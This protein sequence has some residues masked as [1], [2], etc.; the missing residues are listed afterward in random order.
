MQ[1][2]WKLCM[3]ALREKSNSPSAKNRALGEANRTSA[4]ENPTA[5]PANC[6]RMETDTPLSPSWHR[7]HSAM[8]RRV[9][10]I[11]MHL[12]H[13]DTNNHYGKAGFAVRHERT[14]KAR[15][16]TVKILSCVFYRDAWQRAHDTLLHGKVALPCAF[17]N[18][19]W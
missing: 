2:A 19:T 5:R 9:F 17:S 16:Y 6:T 7:N 4:L 12:G 10:S 14:T 1:H 3:H 11:H 8:R 18:P 15:K 13:Q